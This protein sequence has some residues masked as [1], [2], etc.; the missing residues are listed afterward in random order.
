MNLSLI[1]TLLGRNCDNNM[2]HKCT[3]ADNVLQFNKKLSETSLNLPEEFKI[4]NPYNGK[5]KEKVYDMTVKFY[6]KYY[7]D[8]TNR[9]LILGSSPARRGSAITGIPFEDI[10]YLQ[11]ETGVKISNY[12]INRASSSFMEEVIERWGGRSKFYAQFY[13]N[14]VCP[15][16][17][18]KVDS[19]GKETNCN[20]Y[21]SRILQKALYDFIIKSIQNQI[22]LGI[23]TSIC[24]CIG[25]GCNFKFLNKINHKYAFFDEIIPLEHPRFIMQYNSKHK[26]DFLNK[27]INELK[28]I[29]KL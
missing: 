10:T 20:Y 13:M 6:Q 4:I 9:H 26:H 16:G 3:F 12:F 8:T 23:D 11:N 2:K 15:L 17:I 18:S 1:L 28:K 7:D 21:D 19:M 29:N 24:F 5:E 27:Y 14:F 22:G 25:S